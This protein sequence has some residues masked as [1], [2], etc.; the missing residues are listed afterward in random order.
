M[1]YKDVFKI[2]GCLINKNDQSA[3]FQ[4]RKWFDHGNIRNSNTLF[5]PVYCAFLG[6]VIYSYN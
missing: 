3:L 1:E 5:F 6:K 4:N 2:Q